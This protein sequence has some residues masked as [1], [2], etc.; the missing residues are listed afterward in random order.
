MRVGRKALFPFFIT[1]LLLS[2][3][4]FANPFAK[5]GTSLGL[6]VGSG[7]A[8]NSSYT[9]LGINASYFVID[10]LLTGIEYR[11]WFGAS[12]TINE[13]SV[14]VTYIAPIHKKFRPYL[15]SFYRR[16]FVSS[17]SRV[18]SSE[19]DVYGVRAGISVVTSSSSYASLGW[20][21]EFY[22][23]SSNSYPEIVVGISF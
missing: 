5:G 20:V 16:T 21:E 17:T 8:Y 2:S 18:P 9:V 15:G 13:V 10:N 4:L 6:V 22:E 3:S 12:P 11:G 23:N 7:S 14:P 1:G 19:Y